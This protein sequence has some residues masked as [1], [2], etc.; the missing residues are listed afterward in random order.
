MPLRGWFAARGSAHPVA[1]SML[2]LAAGMIACMVIAVSI[3]VSASNRAIDRAI[4]LER[5]NR[6][7]EASRAAELAE[8]DRLRRI[9]ERAASCQFINTILTAYRE[10]PPRPPTKTYQNIVEAWAGLAERCK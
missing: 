4:Q 9:E 8:K 3:S 5:Q 1:Y 10:D 7:D 6:A 2:T